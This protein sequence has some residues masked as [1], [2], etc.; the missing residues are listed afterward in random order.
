MQTQDQSQ[1]IRY[2]TKKDGRL[3]F[4]I[5]SVFILP[6]ILGIILVL[7]RP[8]ATNHPVV[9]GVILLLG[10]VICWILFFTLMYPSYYEIT[11]SALIVKSG[12]YRRAIPLASIQKVYSPRVVPHATWS[13]DQL[14]VDYKLPHQ[15]F[16]HALFV[17]PEDKTT[18]LQDLAEHE[19]D[20][21]IVDGSLMRRGLDL[22]EHNVVEL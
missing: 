2:R 4:L 20:L 16:L 13:F 18:F 5:L 7:A 11:S 3:V 14:R 10:G 19:G 6:F 8:Q 1:V 17:A 9:G 21:A 12:L 15:S 22:T